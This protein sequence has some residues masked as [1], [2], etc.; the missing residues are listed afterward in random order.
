MTPT[1]GVAAGSCRVCQKAGARNGKL[2]NKYCDATSC[3]QVGVDEGHIA[4]AGKRQRAQSPAAWSS[5]VSMPDT[6]QLLEIK[7]IFDCRC[8]RPAPCRIPPDANRKRSFLVSQIM[9]ARQQG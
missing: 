7:S 3:V 4:H 1:S 5:P 9:Q 6:W 2:P 8:T